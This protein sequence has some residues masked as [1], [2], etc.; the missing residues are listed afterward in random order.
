[1]IRYVP[2]EA[3]RGWIQSAFETVGMPTA[4]ARDSAEM[5]VQTSLWGID[6]HGVARTGHY[7]ERLTRKSIVAAPALAF[8]RSAPGA[9]T[10]DGGDGLGFVVSQYAMQRA[11][12]LA[13]EAGIGAV[14]VRNSSHCGAVG[15]Y[16]RLATRAGMVGI[17]FTHSD[18]FVIPYGGNKKFF[19]TNPISIAMPST[20]PRRPFCVDMATSI[21]PWNRIANAKR[22]NRAIASGLAVDAEGHDTTD[23][24]QVAAVRPTAEHKGYAL[25]FAID[26]LCGPLNGMKF[27]PH[28]TPMY[29][30]LDEKRKLGSFMIAIDPQRFGGGAML[31]AVVATAMSEVKQQAGVISPGDPEYRTEEERLRTGIPIEPGLRE[32]FAGWAEK[33]KLRLPEGL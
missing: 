1:M 6:S 31:A 25:A 16:A 8:E 11:I 17:A 10:V 13:K 4:A 14:G 28:L 22:E 33:L 21:V 12:E 32:E 15:L 30:A 24:K 5:L 20:D 29:T 18:A 19:G 23:P 2:A 27:G 7:L 9:G 3:M 26:M